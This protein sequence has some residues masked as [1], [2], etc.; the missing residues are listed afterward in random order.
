VEPLE[1]LHRPNLR[2]SDMG[3][4]QRESMVRVMFLGLRSLIHPAPDLDVSR[5]WY[6]EI[7]G[8]E[9]Y[10][11]EPFYVGFDV[12]GYELGLH[13]DGDPT[14]G[15]KTYWGVAEVE[16]ALDRL[17]AAGATLEEPVTEVGAGI[18]MAAV[19]DPAGCFLGI[20][21]NPNFSVRQLESTGP[22]R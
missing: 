11:D 7:L 16:P 9:P 12:G 8:S 15:P 18:R 2:N 19:R 4:S 5:A 14:V 3:L 6:T 17:G 10:F 13:P 20:I 21:E 1:S 22:G